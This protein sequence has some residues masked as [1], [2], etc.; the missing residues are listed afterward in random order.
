M[1]WSGEPRTKVVRSKLRRTAVEIHDENP[2]SCPYCSFSQETTQDGVWPKSETGMVR[3]S[4]CSGYD[5]TCWEITYVGRPTYLLKF[6]GL[7]KKCYLCLG[8]SPSSHGYWVGLCRT[9][10][11]FV[12]IQILRVKLQKLYQYPPRNREGSQTLFLCLS[13]PVSTRKFP[14]NMKICEKCL[15]FSIISSY[16]NNSN[17]V[18]Q[19]C[20]KI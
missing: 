18:L 15:F 20:C 12:P 6:L 13:K 17:C 11:R 14:K 10:A 1:V 7:L 9:R 16:F 5:V 2:R 19:F 3:N 4:L 8:W